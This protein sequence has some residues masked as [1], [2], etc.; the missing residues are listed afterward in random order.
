MRDKY[1]SPDVQ[2]ESESIVISESEV[3]ITA[4]RSSGPGGQG[5]NKT[6]T[7]VELR[8][9]LEGSGLLDAEQKDLVRE[10]LSTRINR[11]GVL[12]LHAQQT[13]SQTQNRGIALERLNTLVNGALEVP[14]ERVA[15]KKR[16]GTKV[17]ERKARTQLKQKKDL[18]RKPTREDY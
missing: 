17:K 18:R 6:S 2:G 4:A 12:V 7:K 15:T 11:Q 14:K 8:W 3:E 10:K 1:V 9:D 16:Q 5:V 13:R